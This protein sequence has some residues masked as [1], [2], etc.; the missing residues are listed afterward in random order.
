[1]L[2]QELDYERNAFLIL[3]GAHSPFADQFFWLF[4]G[5]MI[6][7]PFAVVFIAA[8]FYKNKNRWKETLLI[9]SA[10]FLVIICCDQFASG[11]CKP[12]FHRLRPT[13]HPQFMNQVQTVF[14][15]RGG[16]YGFISSHAANAFGFVTLTAFI[17][18]YKIY[19]FTIFLWALIN[20]YSRI[21]LGVHFIS[22]IV[23]GM[24]AG[25]FFGWAVYQV[26][27]FMNNKLTFKKRKNTYSSYPKKNIN[28][29]LYTFALTIIFMLSISI[30]Y[31]NK[32]IQP[33]TAG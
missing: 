1:M 11:F 4:S 23:G 32:L 7:I 6:W 29:I 8:L 17:F 28:I 30:L 22:D 15:Y 13:Y 19:T 2:E 18:R 26:Y 25:I 20:S 24:L 14:D 16:K 31:S 33:I 12:F 10:I 5:K 21:Y 27:I 3:N 9:L